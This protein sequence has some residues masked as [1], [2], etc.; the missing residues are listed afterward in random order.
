MPKESEKDTVDV[1][2]QSPIEVNQDPPTRTRFSG[3]KHFADFFDST[4]QVIE[5]K[6]RQP[7]WNCGLNLVLIEKIVIS[8]FQR[9]HHMV[10]GR[11]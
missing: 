6:V 7:N 1:V 3:R 11:V 5:T 8:K 2:E 4:T 9:I 10:Y